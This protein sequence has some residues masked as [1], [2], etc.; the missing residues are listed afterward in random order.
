MLMDAVERK[1]A[2]MAEVVN[3]ERFRRARE[4]IEVLL[5]RSYDARRC[6]NPM[7]LAIVRWTGGKGRPSSYCSRNCRRQAAAERARILADIDE[8]TE[9]LCNAEKYQDARH[10][11]GQIARLR[12]LLAAYSVSRNEVDRPT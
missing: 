2:A 5:R 9:A 3:E 4:P 12:W 10:H 1:R 6:E 11:Q 8:Q 7:C